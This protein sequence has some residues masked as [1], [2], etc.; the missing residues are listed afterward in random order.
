MKTMNLFMPLMSAWFCFTLPAGM[1]IYW[2][3][4]SVV[5]SIQQVLINKHI[6]KMDF[7]QIIE[8]N[9]SKSAK[10]MEKIQKNQDLINAYANMNTKNIQKRANVS[11]S[12][13]G[14]DVNSSDMSPEVSAKPGSM[15][16]KAN[17]VSEY[18][19]KNKR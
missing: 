2:V 12:D 9:A 16:S 13:N 6:D 17:M 11:S 15:M 19:K 1:G 18:N 7:D 3:A 4:S 8:K 5:R 10:K 14:S